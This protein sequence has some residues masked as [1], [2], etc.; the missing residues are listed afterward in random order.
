LIKSFIFFLFELFAEL[1]MKRYKHIVQVILGEHKGAGVKSGVRC[2]W[3]SETDGYT[4]E[5]FSNVSYIF[6]YF[7]IKMWLFF[8]TQYSVWLLYMQFIY[9]KYFKIDL[10]L[11]E[12]S[13]IKF[14]KISN[15][16]NCKTLCSSNTTIFIM[17]KVRMNLNK[18]TL[19]GK[20]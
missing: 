14:L 15:Y 13:F 2:L 1:K 20:F 18:T 5:I 17:F 19:M 9:I 6:S 8:R 12:L 16:F 10:L 3:D 4:S 7:R 11:I